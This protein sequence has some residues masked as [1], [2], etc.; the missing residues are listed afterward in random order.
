MRVLV[1][2]WFSFLDGEATAGDVG[3][4]RTVAAA[5]TGAGI[6]HDI[7]WS[8]AFRPGATT[9]E[10]ADP[11]HYSH[12]L[13]VC[14][15][16]HGDQ[17]RRLHERYAR[18]RRVAVGVSVIDPHDPAVRGFHHLIARD[19]PG[20]APRADLAHSAPV[21]DGGPVVGVVVAPR[22]PEY[23]RRGAHEAIHGR[24]TGWLARRDCARLPLDTRLAW[25]E[26]RHCAT[27]A[28][29]DALVRRVDVVVTTRL[30]GLVLALR[31]GVPALAVDPV[32]GGAKV[33]AQARAWGWPVV[34]TDTGTLPVDLLERTWEWCLSPDA[35]TAAQ[36]LAPAPPEQAPLAA[37]LLDLLDGNADPAPAATRSGPETR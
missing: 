9:L 32:L 28:Q 13:F 4:A 16:A 3:S 15:P 34:V 7:A 19:A 22:Q 12:L 26:W 31:N 29:F 24:L 35:R 27:P 1:T 33:A 6:A 10:D 20:R 17:V 14:G 37:G 30:H 8:P 21:E 36:A 18:C 2:G 23:G 11:H 5:L 25:E